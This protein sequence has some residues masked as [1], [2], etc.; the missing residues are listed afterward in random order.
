[1]SLDSLHLSLLQIPV[2]RRGCGI[3]PGE[4]FFPLKIM[5]VDNPKEDLLFN[6]FPDISPNALMMMNMLRGLSDRATGSMPAMMG[7]P[8]EYAK[9]RATFSGQ[10]LQVQQG[11]KLGAS[12]RENTADGLGEIAQLVVFQLVRNRGLVDASMM[13]A[14]EQAILK[15]AININIEDIPSRFKFRINV[16]EVNETEEMKRQGML[17]LADLYAKY[18]MQVFQLVPMIYNEQVPQPIRQ[19]GTKFFT[20]AT[21]MMEK[22]LK[23]F[24]EDDVRKYLPYTKDLEMMSKMIETMKDR[25]LGVTGGNL[26]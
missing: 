10:S 11:D 14:E 6:K 2:V 21:E 8:D 15:E 17:M 24:G 20:G 23:Y 5:Q 13:S 22:I 3:G 4:E 25:Q 26:R 9:T 12:I 18:G 16:T 7:Y 19:L 1:M